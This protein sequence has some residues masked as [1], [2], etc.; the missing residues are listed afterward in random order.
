MAHPGSCKVF[1]FGF[2]TVLISMLPLYFAKPINLSG[3]YYSGR[4]LEVLVSRF[5]LILTWQYGVVS[6]IN[7]MRPLQLRLV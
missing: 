7:S 5:D 2:K 6:P 1:D 4:W 3:L